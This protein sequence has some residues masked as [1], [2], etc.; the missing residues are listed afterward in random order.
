MPDPTDPAP[1]APRR[2]VRFKDREFERDNPPVQ[3]VDAAPAFDVRDLLELANKAPKAPP[4]D[5]PLPPSIAPPA[6]NDV[7]AILR[8]NLERERERG[9]YEVAMGKRR[10]SRRK[11]DYWALLIGLNALLVA[12]AF[13]IGLNVVTAVYTFSG[14]ILITIGLTWIMWFIMDDY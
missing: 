6:T 2:E 10:P 12:F 14:I 8:A 7:H 9:L 11:R 4:A 1:E 13:V 5:S 3:G